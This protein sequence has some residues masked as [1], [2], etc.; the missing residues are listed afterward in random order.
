MDDGMARDAQISFFDIGKTGEEYLSTG[1]DIA[2]LFNTAYS[3]G[4]RVHSD[5]WGGSATYYTEECQEFD[6]YS[7]DHQDFLILV[8]A[9]NDGSDGPNSVTSPAQVGSKYFHSTYLFR[10]RILYLKPDR[11]CLTGQKS[12]LCR[13]S[14]NKSVHKRPAHQ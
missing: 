5:S 6:T 1:P 14:H 13:I 12:C 2:T 8:A 9:G 11:Y 4:A 3:A 7:H 10:Y